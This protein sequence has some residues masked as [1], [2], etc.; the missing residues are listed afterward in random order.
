MTLDQ[1]TARPSDRWADLRTRYHAALVDGDPAAA[2]ALA[3]EVTTRAELE[4][5]F[6][7]VIQPAMYTIGDEWERGEVSVAQEH[8]ASAISSRVVSS[9]SSARR[10][11][12]PWRG[13]A[14]VSAVANEFHELGA[15]MVADLLEADGWEVSYLGANAPIEDLVSL[16]Q[17][18]R[19]V[20]LALSVTMPFNLDRARAIIAA[21]RAPPLTPPL[22]VLVGG[23]AFNL[24]PGSWQEVGADAWAKDAGEAVIQARA[25]GG[26]AGPGAEPSGQAVAAG[27]PDGEGWPERPWFHGPGQPGAAQAADGAGPGDGERRGLGDGRLAQADR[28]VLQTMSRLNAEVTNLGRDLER[29]NRDLQRALEEIKTLRGILP[30]CMHC[31]KI[32]NDAGLWQRLET[33]VMQNSEAQFSHG[34]CEACFKEHYPELAGPPG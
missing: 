22:R 13:R 16:V 29:K 6:L 33:Y 30:I 19:P 24:Q 34:L 25:L 1:P 12:R 17:A 32:K 31:K 7:S 14:V 28:E 27:P 8:L 2:V 11:E 5:F 21:A 4:A 10:L 9:L 26:P 15:W 18:R 3:G 23:R 20:L